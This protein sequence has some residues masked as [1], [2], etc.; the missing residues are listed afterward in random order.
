MRNSLIFLFGFALLLVQ[1]SLSVLIPIHPFVPVLLLP[2]ALYLGVTP[3]V[4]FLRGALIAFVLGVISDETT[5][6]P[7]GYG[8]FLFVATFLLSRVAAFRLF[9]RG[10]P[11]QIGATTGIAL[12]ASAAM[13]AVCAILSDNGR[14][15]FA[16]EMTPGGW[17]GWVLEG[18]ADADSLP[19]VGAVT[20]I[21]SVLFGSAL[22]TGLVSP[23]VYT[24]VRRIETFT[25]RVR[26]R[27]EGQRTDGV[28]L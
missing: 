20:N 14:E 16:L 19:R 23:L 28:M 11:F 17:A 25:L 26:T 21:A 8:T 15:P 3:E 22:A 27:P 18:A 12:L 13:L 2:M 10:V 7:L 5:G 1:S 24:M 4:G 6:A 9:L